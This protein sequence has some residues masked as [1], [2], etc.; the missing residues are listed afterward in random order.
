[1][2]NPYYW[3]PWLISAIAVGIAI[4]REW[5]TDKSS[6]Q[7]RVHQLEVSQ[8]VDRAT[9]NGQLELIRQQLTQTST[10]AK[11]A[12]QALKTILENDY[13]N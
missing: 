12:H 4:W 6:L 10:A 5:R 8:A 1:M 11:G 13:A 3:I 7:N 9:V 2:Q